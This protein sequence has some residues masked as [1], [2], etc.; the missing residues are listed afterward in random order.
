MAAYC[1]TVS[2]ATCDGGR[3][4]ANYARPGSILQKR[5]E[6]EDGVTHD[7]LE[8]KSE[9]AR[10]RENSRSAEHTGYRRFP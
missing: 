1:S 2:K 7:T 3:N 10:R 5:R 9:A 8:A 4:E 6:H